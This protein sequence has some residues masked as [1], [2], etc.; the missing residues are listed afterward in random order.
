MNALEHISAVD[1]L[2][3]MDD[4]CYLTDPGGII[5]LVGL[6]RWARFALEGD[7]PG[8]ADPS[9]ILGRSLYEFIAGEDVRDGYRR[10][11]RLLLAGDRDR[12]RLHFRC[13]G[14]SVARNVRLVITPLR[15]A[16]RLAGLLHRCTVLS[17]ERRAPVA[18][19]DL[20]RQPLPGEDAGLLAICSYCKRVRSRGDG[21][22]APAPLPGEG[23]PEWISAEDYLRGGGAPRVRL[24]HG[25]CPECRTHIVEPA[26]A[27]LR[28]GL[29]AAG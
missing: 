26:I 16:G 2:E 14:P 15:H 4:V 28:A 5:R 7:A 8:L 29:R 25:I 17:S 21:P 22:E 18:L 1:W 10:M 24:S 23:P 6:G 19:L 9:R 27:D 20:H 13:D 3:A 12:I 11:H